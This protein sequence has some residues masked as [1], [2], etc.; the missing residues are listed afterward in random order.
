MGM[1]GVDDTARMMV[2][3]VEEEA[4]GVEAEGDIE[5]V[6]VALGVGEEG[7]DGEICSLEV[8]TDHSV[9]FWEAK[10]LFCLFTG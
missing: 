3:G 2:G 5:A 4:T 9:A 1:V 8:F 10:K 6:E 7:E